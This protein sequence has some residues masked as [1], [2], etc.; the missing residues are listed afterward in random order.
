MALGYRKTQDGDTWHFCCN[1]FN[2][3]RFSYIEQWQP[4]TVGEMCNECE[5]RRREGNCR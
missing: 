3:P 1:C 5:A 4:P 2:W